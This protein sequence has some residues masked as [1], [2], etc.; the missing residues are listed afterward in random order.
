MCAGDSVSRTGEQEIG[1][2]YKRFPRFL[3]GV[4]CMYVILSAKGFLSGDKVDSLSP[5]E[6]NRNRL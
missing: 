5:E 2:K 1:F 4:T 3:G 6:K